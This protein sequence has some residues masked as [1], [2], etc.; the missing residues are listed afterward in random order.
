MTVELDVKPRFADAT[1]SG[2]AGGLI[3]PMPGKILEVRAVVG[4]RVTAGQ[5]LVIM[6]AMKMEHH[7]SSPTDGVV[8]GVLTAVGEQV[9]TA[10]V[11]LVV[12][13]E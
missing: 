3:A 7:L 12:D 13:A 8:T 10:A 4:D 2:P 5:V 11:L 1:S 9:A 6:E